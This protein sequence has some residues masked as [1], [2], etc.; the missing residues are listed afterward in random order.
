MDS[1]TRPMRALRRP[2]L[3]RRWT[4]LLG[5]LVVLAI[6][7]GVALA[8]DYFTKTS[9]T[10][11]INGQVLHLR[12]HAD[13][14]AAALDEAGVLLDPEDQVWP[15]PEMA[16]ADGEI[17]A[18]RK[19]HAVALQIGPAVR[20][21]RTQATHPLEILAGQGIRPGVHDR[22]QVN[23]ADYSPEQLAVLTWPIAPLTIRVIPSVPLTIDDAGR[24]FIVY[25]TQADVGRAL[26]SAGLKLYLADR[27]TPALSAPVSAGLIVTIERSVPF[28][29]I[30]DGHRLEA[31]A[32]G[33]TVADALQA[34]NLAP[35]GLDYTIPA[36]DA[37]LE[38]GMTIQ[39]VRVTEEV[40]ANDEA[41]PFTTI[42][43][44]NLGLLADEKHVVQEGIAGIR[45]RVLRVR[46]EDGAEVSR[47]LQDEWIAKPPVPRMVIIGKQ[48]GLP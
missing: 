34:I 42:Y 40:V 9:A 29:V 11:T 15:A 24:R 14:V 21:I 16:L 22:V 17:I 35:I 47:M 33:P 43:Q 18:V 23:G 26:D 41:I 2:P 44:P 19:A 1:I 7:A 8:V 28:T 25:T 27:V 12:T 5:L 37:P 36:L 20:Q 6:L 46:Y 39:L 48:A 32:L 30:A 31:R 4:R 38:A 3:G 10:I 13:T 45:T